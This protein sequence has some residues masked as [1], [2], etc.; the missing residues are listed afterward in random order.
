MDK[1]LVH[2]D[3]TTR[4]EIYLSRNH[5]YQNNPERPTVHLEPY[6]PAEEHLGSLAPL[7]CARK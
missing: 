7:A 2:N 5:P 1:V 3:R 6:L 4:R